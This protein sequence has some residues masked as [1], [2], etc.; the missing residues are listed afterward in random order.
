MTGLTVIRLKCVSCGTE[1]TFELPTERVEEWKAGQYIQVAFPEMTADD[2]EFLITSRG[3]HP[4]CGPCFDRQWGG[5][6]G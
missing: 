4:Q 5:L 3:G 6:D 2:R 1:K